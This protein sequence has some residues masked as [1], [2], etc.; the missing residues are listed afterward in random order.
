MSGYRLPPRIRAGYLD[1]RLLLLLLF[2]CTL[3]QAL[4]LA[5]TRA[6]PPP[7]PPRA[8]LLAHIYDVTFPPSSPRVPSFARSITPSLFL[9][10]AYTC[11]T[12]RAHWCSQSCNGEYYYCD[13]RNNA[14]SPSA[15]RKGV[16][17]RGRRCSIRY[18][19]PHLDIS[20]G[21]PSRCTLLSREP[22]SDGIRARS[23]NR[24]LT[25]LSFT[26]RRELSVSGIDRSTC[27]MREI[28]AQSMT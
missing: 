8:A 9:S 5:L 25:L 15:G 6:P 27:D 2:W 11:V 12:L 26:R 21:P 22:I 14:P 4:Q 20:P 17:W 28:R 7:P 1:P 18:L 3:G 24:F 19:A 23:E 13:S 10:G 16:G